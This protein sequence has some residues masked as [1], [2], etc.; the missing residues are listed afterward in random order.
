MPITT[1]GTA[2]DIL[3]QVAA[4]IGL[5]PQVDPYASQ[6]DAFIQMRY[7]L[8]T[9]GNELIISYPWELMNR[10]ATINTTGNTDGVFPLPDDFY[11]ML[12]Q[13]GWERSQ[14][15]PMFGPLSPQDWQYLL[16]RDLVTSTIYASFRIK[17]GTFNVFPNDPPPQDLDIHYEYMSK[18]WVSDGASV[19][20]Y[21]AEV[22]NGSDVPLYDKTLISRYL[23]VKMLSAKGFDTG[24][25]K[26]DF[27]QI[28]GFLT[29]LDKG[30][31]IL[32]AGSNFGFPYLNSWRNLPDSG[33]GL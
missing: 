8:N 30:S 16:G 1:V 5:S 13:T 33:F 22:T 17:E 10:E 7:L 19:P 11:Y 12:D 29:G 18:N 2:N 23:K 27:A 25:A 20:T 32:N 14:N 28:F 9:A 31:E 3:N 24:D 26:E 6:D 21:K 15:V 4:E